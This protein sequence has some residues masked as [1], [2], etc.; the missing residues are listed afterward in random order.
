M[1]IP[2]HASALSDHISPIPMPDS[3]REAEVLYLLLDA[4]LCPRLQEDP[5]QEESDEGLERDSGL[6]PE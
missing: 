4:G 3:K 6:K 5:D 2:N 1:H